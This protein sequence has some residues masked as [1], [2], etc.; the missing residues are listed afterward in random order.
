[1]TKNIAKDS[2]YER[3]DS[4]FAAA[5]IASHA[6][7]QGQGFR[8]K[9][10]RFLVE[11]FSNWV[12]LGKQNLRTSVQTTQILRYLEIL[13]KEDFARKKK[14]G[15]HPTYKLTRHGLVFLLEL[16]VNK[17]YVAHSGQFFF[18]YYFIKNY[19]HIIEKL[20]ADEGSLFPKALKIELDLLFDE[21]EFLNKEINA[22]LKEEQRLKLRI[23]DGLSASTLTKNNLA[24]KIPLKQIITEIEKHHPYELNSQKPL[25]ELINE[26]PA[27]LQQWE[28]EYGSYYRAQEIWSPLLGQVQHYIRE[29]SKLKI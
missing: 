11:L 28:M 7:V 15:A 16:I 4:L 10:L 21:Q 3:Y 5:S 1:M 8:Q 22:A 20:I 13:I 9:Q 19:K 2:I 14:V 6:S 18:F 25:S 27:G 17:N 24:K 26:I 12:E 23:N 29:L